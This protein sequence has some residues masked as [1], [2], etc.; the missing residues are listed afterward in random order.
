MSAALAGAVDEGDRRRRAAGASRSAGDRVVHALGLK[1]TVDDDAEDRPEGRTRRA[2]A[3]VADRR[4]GG[5][6]R[7]SGRA[8]AGRLL[9][10]R[11]ELGVVER[12]A[13][14]LHFLGGVVGDAEAVAQPARVEAW[15]QVPGL[16]DARRTRRRVLPGRHDV[17]EL[18]VE[19]V[20]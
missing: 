9:L 14:K 10:E 3:P 6:E 13:A 5:G 11:L 18:A 7:H 12:A 1:L 19:P 8:V 15:D 2:A 17:D 4:A 16:D 20:V